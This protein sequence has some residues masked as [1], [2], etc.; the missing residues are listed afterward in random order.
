MII[1]CETA[2]SWLHNLGFSQKNHHKG[3]YFNGHEHSDVVTYKSEFVSK[4]M[5]LEPFCARPGH[6]PV[7]RAG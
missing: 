5:E 7:S 3:V 1:C 6:I 2:R 4:V